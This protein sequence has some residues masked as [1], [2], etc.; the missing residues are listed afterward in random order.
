MICTVYVV[1][2]ARMVLGTC[3]TLRRI[4]QFRRISASSIWPPANFISQQPVIVCSLNRLTSSTFRFLTTSTVRTVLVRLFESNEVNE[5]RNIL[6]CVNGR[7]AKSNENSTK[8]GSSNF[9]IRFVVEIV[10]QPKIEPGNHW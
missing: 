1:S 8:F 6:R 10:A 4:F 5:M 2:S 3:L 9:G 7:R